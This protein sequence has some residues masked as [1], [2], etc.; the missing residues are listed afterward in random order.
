M[1]MTREEAIEELEHLL[2]HW[3]DLEKGL[4]AAVP[5][6]PAPGKGTG[7]GSGATGGGNLNE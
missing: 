1:S 5:G 6:Q 2:S 4:A 7:R 3:D